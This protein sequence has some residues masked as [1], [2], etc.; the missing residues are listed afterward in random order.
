MGE[1]VDFETAWKRHRPRT[2]DKNVTKYKNKRNNMEY[3]NI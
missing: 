1:K 2:K 3:A